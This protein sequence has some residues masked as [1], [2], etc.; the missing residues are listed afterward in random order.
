MHPKRILGDSASVGAICQGLIEQE[1][2]EKTE[3]EINSVFS[4][5]GVK[6]TFSFKKLLE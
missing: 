4:F 1:E 2:A 5:W 6:C 3:D